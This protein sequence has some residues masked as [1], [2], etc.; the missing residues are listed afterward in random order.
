MRRKSWFLWLAGAACILAA[1][2]IFSVLGP[3]TFVYCNEIR[4]GHEIVSRINAFRAHNG[5]LPASIEEIGASGKDLDKF[6][7]QRCSDKQF[8]VWFGTTLGESMTFD[9]ASNSWTSVNIVCR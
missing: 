6:L 1:G 9:S 3:D 7:Y 4:R 5:R 8:N 2:A